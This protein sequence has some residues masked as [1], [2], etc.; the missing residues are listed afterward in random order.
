MSLTIETKDGRVIIQER[1]PGRI[2]T[3]ELPDAAM[4]LEVLAAR[5]TIPKS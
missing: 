5:L 4:A 2:A 1:I 3:W